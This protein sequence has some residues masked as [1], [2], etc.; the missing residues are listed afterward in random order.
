MTIRRFERIRFRL[1]RLLYKIAA[2]LSIVSCTAS[3]APSFLRDPSGPN[4][5]SCPGG[6]EARP[7]GCYPVMG[8]TL[9]DAGVP[10]LDDRTR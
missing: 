3:W 4:V 1:V 6:F 8:A 5:A 10:D 2:L 7:G 9:V